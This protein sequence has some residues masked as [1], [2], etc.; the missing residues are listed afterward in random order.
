MPVSP[1]ASDLSFEVM[2][3]RACRQELGTQELDSTNQKLHSVALRPSIFDAFIAERHISVDSNF[4]R[5]PV[6]RLERL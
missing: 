2:K 4:P 5:G 6:D 3:L 1:I